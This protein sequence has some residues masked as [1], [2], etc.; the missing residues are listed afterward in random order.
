MKKRDSSRDAKANGAN[1]TPETG[2]F[3]DT[4]V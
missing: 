2:V 4:G 1:Y 3:E